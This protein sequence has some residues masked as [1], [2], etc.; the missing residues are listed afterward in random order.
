[1]RET[2]APRRVRDRRRAW[3]PYLFISPWIIG[4][5]A[6]TLG[7]LLFSAVMSFFDWPVIGTPRFV[8]IGNYA[9]MLTGDEQFWRS[10]G[11]TLKFAVF[12][13]PLNIVVALLL[14]LLISRPVKGA[15]V[16]RALFYLPAVVSSVAVSVIWGWILNSE[17]GLLNYLLSLFGI[18]GPRW[19]SDPT[20]AIVA[21]VIASLWGLGTMMLIFYT[22]LKSI[23]R[24]IYED[25]LIAGA[26]PVRQFFAITLPLITPSLLFNLITSTIGAM[27]Q[28]SL[29]LLLT[30][31][32]PLKSTHFYG[33]YVYQNA[34]KHFKLGYASANAWFMFFVILALTALLFKSSAAWVFYENEVAAKPRKGG[35]S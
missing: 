15:S 26:S 13:V 11:I 32:G 21:I 31:G 34:F 1:M 25:A 30:K 4:F 22:A 35:S 29:V 23:P 10:L 8:G 20:W 18:Q 7:P 17:Y 16:F 19:L 2:S 14:A 3:A 28:L 5:V 9:K 6:F 24:D 12:F 33:L 27:Q